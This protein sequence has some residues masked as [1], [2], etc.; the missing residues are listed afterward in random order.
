MVD[1][2]HRVDSS[3]SGVDTSDHTVVTIGGSHAM[4]TGAVD[5]VQ[6]VGI[7]LSISLSLGL[8]LAVVMSVDTVVDARDSSVSSNGSV[9]SR[10]SSHGVDSGD[11]G[12][13]MVAIGGN[14]S[15]VDS[16][17]SS[18][19]VDSSHRVDSGDSSSHGGVDSGDSGS[20]T[21][22]SSDHTMVAV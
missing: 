14:H 1:S 19:V 8:T 6:E 10:D 16:R 9:D 7:S 4:D 15:G 22:D 17:D 5:S 13:N 12:S 3:N 20:N 18:H 11:S 2:S 21:V